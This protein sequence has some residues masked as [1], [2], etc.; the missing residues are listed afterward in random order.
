M[1]SG[2]L[3]QSLPEFSEEL[4]TCLGSGVG[5]SG[6]GFRRPQGRGSQPPSRRRNMVGV[7]N[8]PPNFGAASRHCSGLRAEGLLR[9]QSLFGLRRTGLLGESYFEF[10]SG[11]PLPWMSHSLKWGR[12]LVSF[13]SFEVKKG[14]TSKFTHY[15]RSPH[16][17]FQ[18]SQDLT[19]PGSPDSVLPGFPGFIPSKQHP[20]FHS[21]RP[22]PKMPQKLGRR[23]CIQ[24][25]RSPQVRGA[26]DQG[27][28]ELLP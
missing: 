23:C 10:R 17:R 2:A 19:R 11:S 20:K 16:T 3:S 7:C 6:L 14:D 1:V 15:H 8:E 27:S 4:S 22:R 26:P 12:Q 9:C 5:R 21:P 24:E 25:E 28:T 18:E 13:F